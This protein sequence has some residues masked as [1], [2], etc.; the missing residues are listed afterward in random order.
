MNVRTPFIATCASLI[1]L[2]GCGHF[3]MEKCSSSCSASVDFGPPLAAGT[4]YGPP[5]QTPGTVVYSSTGVTMSVEKFLQLSGNTSFNQASITTPAPAGPSG[6]SLA[7]NNISLRFTFLPQVSE[8]TF[9]FTDFGG[10]E[11]FSVNGSP[12]NTGELTSLPS[13]VN[14]VSV[15]VT[16]TA[17][18]GA[19]GAHIGKR[20]TL[21]MRGQINEFVVG[22]QELVIDNVCGVK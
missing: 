15:I 3:P 2:S 22:G 20:G 21:H 13:L 5:A 16:S 1:A 6:Q 18:I 9:D 19:G 4:R 11:N 10:H 17:I 8:V 7:V 14:G 12:V